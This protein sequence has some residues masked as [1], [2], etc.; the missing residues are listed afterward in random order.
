MQERRSEALAQDQ[1][2]EMIYFQFS[3]EGRVI[4]A[5]STAQTQ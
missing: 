4:P 2:P 1:L 3:M 5:F